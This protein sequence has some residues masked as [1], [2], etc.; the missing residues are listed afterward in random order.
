[1]KTSHHHNGFDKLCQ[2]IIKIKHRE[3]VG[4]ICP[5]MKLTI[6]SSL[7]FTLETFLF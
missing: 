2:I 6:D 7:H 5:N 3:R 4:K 1:M